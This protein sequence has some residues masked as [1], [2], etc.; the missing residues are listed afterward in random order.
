MSQPTRRLLRAAWLAL[1]VGFGPCGAPA[2]ELPPVVGAVEMFATDELS[3]VALSGFDPVSYFL[4]EG[5]KPGQT[6]QEIIWNGVAWRF[7]SAANRNAF[8]RDSEI[9]TPRLGGYDATA[10]ARGLIVRANPALYIIRDSRL[11]LFRSDHTRARFLAD[12]RLAAEA[13]ERWPRLRA[14]LVEP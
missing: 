3:G 4:V 12:E 5:P 13:E 10:M 6:D 9:Y 14:E 8:Q 1:A 11:F 7:A 2:A